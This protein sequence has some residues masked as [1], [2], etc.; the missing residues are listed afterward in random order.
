MNDS[1]FKIDNISREDA[2]K[3]KYIQIIQYHNKTFGR[4]FNKTVSNFFLT[5]KDSFFKE[6][7]IPTLI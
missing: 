1:L 7:G 6:Q 3:N 5:M 4:I 2:N